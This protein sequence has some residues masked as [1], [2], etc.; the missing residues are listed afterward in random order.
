MTNKEIVQTVTLKTIMGGKEKKCQKYVPMDVPMKNKRVS[1]LQANPLFLL[2]ATGGFEPPDKGFADLCLTT[3]LRRPIEWNASHRS[4]NLIPFSH[5]SVK[6]KR[7]RTVPQT[8]IFHHP[9]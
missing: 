4:C 9:K 5:R 2:E 3:W 8:K 6:R 1:P 7:N